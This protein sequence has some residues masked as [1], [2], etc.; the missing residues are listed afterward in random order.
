MSRLTGPHDPQSIFNIAG[1]VE[2]TLHQ[3][4]EPGLTSGAS[5]RT[6]KS[7][8]LR[9]DFRVLRKARN[10]NQAFC[11]RNRLFVKGSDPQRQGF[12]EGITCSSVSTSEI[13]SFNG[14]RSFGP[15]M[16]SGG[17]SK[18]TRQYSGALYSLP[19]FEE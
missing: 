1:P 7:V 2:S 18:V 5:N 4:L 8:P 16:L 15:K 13:I 3:C 12:D 9:D 10:I 19:T 6:D 11:L 17:R 14:E